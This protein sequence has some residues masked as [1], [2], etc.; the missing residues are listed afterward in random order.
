MLKSY[1][2]NTQ[3]FEIRRLTLSWRGFMT[4]EGVQGPWA[5]SYEDKQHNYAT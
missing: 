4:K 5:Y 3:I 2:K 1:F